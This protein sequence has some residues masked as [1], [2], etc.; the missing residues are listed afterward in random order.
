MALLKDIPRLF[1]LAWL[2]TA[3]PVQASELTTLVY[4]D[5][6][7]DPGR[8]AFNVSRSI[9]V[10]Q[11]DYLKQNGYR[12]ISLDF[13][14]KVNRG[15]V[16]LPDKAVLL[17]FDDALRSYGEFVAPLM[18]LYGYPTVVSVVGAW[19]GGTEVPEEYRG[20]LMSWDDLRRLRDN[21]LVEIISHSHN[22]H[23]G[24]PS[25]PQ[26][27]VAAAGVTRRYD[28]RVGAYESEAD[29]RQRIRHDMEQAVS[30]FKRHL[31]MVP[32]AIAWPYGY[33]DQ[34]LVEE[35]ERA[36]IHFYMT[37]EN[38]PTPVAELPRIRRIVVRNTGSLTGF[39]DDLQYRYRQADQR[40]VEFS[41]DAFS[42]L[43]ETAREE[44]LSRLLDRLQIMHAT[45]VLVSPFTADRR[46]AFFF[47]R[48]MPV[49]ADILNRVLHQ[50][51]TRLR[52][53]HIYLKLPAG[54]T[55]ADPDEL[56]TDLARLNW[57]SGVVF[58][59]SG[60]AVAESRVRRIVAYYKPVMRFG[61]DGAAAPDRRYDFAITRLDS[62]LSRAEINAGIAHMKPSP[63]RNLVI[64]ERSDTVEAREL[65]ARLRILRGLGV[66]DYGYSPDDYV[67]SRPAYH[68]VAPELGAQSPERRE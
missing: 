7:P 64:L 18:K 2:G 57:F 16:G 54:M 29:F 67:A 52:I 21:P 6:T 3:L 43:T 41:L 35:M 42:G 36:G 40:V 25:N 14:D 63:A 34:V 5:V 17:T 19:A 59:P 9:F 39:I 8:E 61:I 53:Q 47:N 48:R 15:K 27:N 28:G 12:P 45:T 24:I 22:L 23:H 32:R 44:R 68:V 1:A 50:I 38:G 20:K 33:Y 62:G 10:A 37:L 49:S 58:D 55:V 11:M 4:H 60:D 26:G 30:A 66:G 65:A 56:Y 31:G 51:L 13:L 46:E